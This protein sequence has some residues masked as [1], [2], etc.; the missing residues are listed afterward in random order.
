MKRKGGHLYPRVYTKKACK[1]SNFFI[2][3][4]LFGKSKNNSKSKHSGIKYPCEQCEYTTTT[5]SNLKRHKL[6]KH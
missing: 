3:V 6:R 2:W 4:Y 5:T 1:S